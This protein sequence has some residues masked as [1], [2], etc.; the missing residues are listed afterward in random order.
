MPFSSSF[1]VNGRTIG[2]GHKPYLIAEISGNHNQSLE[3]ALELMTACKD[4]GADAIKLQTYTADTMTLNLRERE[5]FVSDDNNLWK[6]QSLY[7]LYEKAHTPWAW[8]PQ[9]FQHAKHL[10]ITI[11][12]TPF[13]ETAVDF[14]EELDVP[15]YKIAS[16]ENTDLPLLQRVART[17]KPVIMSTGMATFRELAASVGALGEA[18]CRD[19]VLLKCTSSYPSLERDANLASLPHIRYA[20]D[21]PVGLSDHSLGTAIPVVATAL[22]A[23][24]IE[25]HVTMDRNDGG[26]DSSFSLVPSEFAHLVQECSKAFDSLGAVHYGCSE[27][28]K[29]SVVYRRSIYVSRDINKGEKFSRDNI[30]VIRPAHGLKPEFM[31]IVLGRVASRDLKL[32]TPLSWDHF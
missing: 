26:V 15:C 1:E 13:D 7:E 14:L 11:F 12:S 25:K 30:K 31:D 18:G 10:G 2:A 28:E 23:S 9:L 8:H 21:V 5:F 4:A 19:L 6:G 32:G 17:R 22:G 20:F 16:F 29:K 24:V 3:R 27:K